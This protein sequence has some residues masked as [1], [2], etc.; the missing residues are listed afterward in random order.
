[1]PNEDL[2]AT[3]ERV[4]FENESGWKII[5]TDKGTA[6]GTVSFDVKPG[7]CLKFTGTWK[8]S[9]FS[10]GREFDF[11]TAILHLPEEPRALL[12]YAVSL[13]K[14]LGEA[15]EEAIWEKY[16]CKWREAE[17]LELPGI[18]EATAFHWR[19]TLRRLTE[20]FVQT[21]A[22]AFLLDHGCTLNLAS[23]AWQQ[24]RANTVGLVNADPYAL[25]DL[26]HYGF[27]WVDENIRPRFGIAGSDPRRIDAAI[28]YVMGQLAEQQGTALPVS[29]I[30]AAVEALLGNQGAALPEQIDALCD[31]GKIVSLARGC[32]AL[33]KDFEHE[34]VIWERWKA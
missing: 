16:G 27:A 3:V 31:A 28:A 34:T 24:W 33:K 22:M 18:S 6:K 14:G 8:H 13:T 4:P 21:Q 11:K 9:E 25:C 12:R 2:I 5:V 20:C 1:M 29:D 15:K 32:L 10:G 19:D 30:G 17:T 7:D 26:P 23:A